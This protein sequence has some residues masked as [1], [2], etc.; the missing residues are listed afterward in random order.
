MDSN[1]APLPARKVVEAVNDIQTPGSRAWLVHEQNQLKRCETNFLNCTVLANVSTKADVIHTAGLSKL[2]L[3]IDDNL[4]VYDSSSGALSNT[5]FSV[6][7]NTFISALASNRDNY[8]F[9]HLGRIFRAP[10]DGSSQAVVISV[11]EGSIG[12]QG[13]ITDS[14]VI[15]TT[16]S[17]TLGVRVRALDV[18]TGVATTIASA[19]IGFSSTL[20]AKG[21]RI[22]F[23]FWKQAATGSTQTRADVSA[24]IISSDGTNSSLYINSSWMGFTIANSFDLSN[25]VSGVLPAKTMFLVTGFNAL[26]PDRGFAQGEMRAFDG[27]TGAP[28]I[29]LG[30]LSG[31]VSQMTC[32]GF[33][34]DALC[35]SFGLKSPAPTAFEI[36]I[37]T[38]IFYVN[39]ELPN[40]LTRI[41]NTQINERPI[42]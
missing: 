1:S 7:A 16:D 21:N 6:P 3:N 36:P 35:T 13:H 10:I 17:P 8:Y 31:T 29:V 28:G 23:E 41:T 12:V 11:E 39:T 18:T 34:T 15:Y 19:P 25:N 30:V 2:L 38:D 37:Q 22:Y 5:I 32:F 24:G 26:G 9:G 20:Y 14:K 42:F 4:R 27:A 40:S 33:S